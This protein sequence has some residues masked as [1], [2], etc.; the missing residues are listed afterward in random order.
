MLSV[1]NA[2]IVSIILSPSGTVSWFRVQPEASI[3]FTQGQFVMIERI[4]GVLWANGKSM[5]KPYSIGTTFREYQT[6]G[7][8]GF[9]V[10]KA[11]EDG[12]SQYLTEW[13]H[14][15]DI[16]KL[17][18]PLWH[19]VDPHHSDKYLLLSTGS[20]L[21]P[22]LSHYMHLSTD[23][24]N[25]IAH[26]FGERN[27]DLLIPE[28]IDQFVDSDQIWH[29]LTLSQDTKIWRNQGYVQHGLEHA[30][31]WLWSTDIIA[32]LCGKPTMVDEVRELLIWYGVD[33][34]RILFEKY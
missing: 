7:T 9:Y 10:K 32:M 28:I 23:P 27:W 18:G 19:F 4:D 33:A 17:T 20:G 16:I 1:F 3:D 6:D 30:L 11:S 34:E 15:W 24:T 31:H 5:K 2:R 12:M 22:I 8:I 29:Y 14:I 25:R 21:T 26:L 13:I